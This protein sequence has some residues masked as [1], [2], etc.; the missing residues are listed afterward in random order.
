MRDDELLSLRKIS[1]SNFTWAKRWFLAFWLSQ[2]FAFFVN[3]ITAFRTFPPIWGALMGFFLATAAELLRW[4]SDTLRSKGETFKRKSEIL[5]AF[6]GYDFSSDVANE[7]A[8]K[9]SGTY[10]ISDDDPFLRGMES[11][12]TAA[13]GPRRALEQLHE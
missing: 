9:T 2:A 7:L 10:D 6:A 4:R 5:D 12:S 3:A 13:K 11:A 8:A 1:A